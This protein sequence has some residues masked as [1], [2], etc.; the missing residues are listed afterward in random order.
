MFS[1]KFEFL[2][3]TSVLIVALIGNVHGHGRLRDPPARSSAWRY[4]S[5]FP[6]EYTD[7]QM[8]CGGVQIQYGQNSKC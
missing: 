6:P 5:R 1:V 7:N 2:F 3:A 4:D 8:F